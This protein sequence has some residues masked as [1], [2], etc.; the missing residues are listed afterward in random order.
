MDRERK[1]KIARESDGVD[2][3]E[4]KDILFNRIKGRN[5]T[6]LK[7]DNNRDCAEIH[8]QIKW[9]RIKGR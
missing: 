6:V 1:R 7:Q 8:K 3:G 5:K 4:R 2:S 9:H